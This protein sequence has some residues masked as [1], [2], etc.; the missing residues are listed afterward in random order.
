MQAQYTLVC[1]QCGQSFA[2]TK[3]QRAVIRH[4][5]PNRMY[6]SQRCYHTARVTKVA[7]ACVVCGQAFLAYPSAIAH[8][9]GNY[10]SH[11]CQNRSRAIPLAQRFWKLV[12]R[13]NPGGCWPWLAA[14]DKDGYGLVTTTP[15]TQ[16]VA[17]RVAYELTYGPFDEALKVCHHCDNPSCCRPNH[18]FLGTPADNN[19]DMVRKARHPHGIKHGRA[20]LTEADVRTIRQRYATEHV[21][22]IKLAEDYGVDQT[23]ISDVVLRKSWRH[24]I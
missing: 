6:C 19:A 16:R 1:P 7:R 10:C 5:L 14:R 4:G 9:Y 18:L 24:V 12:D 22:Q 21:T 11:G 17:H 15:G 20:K 13:S 8:G 23:I 2:P 3:R